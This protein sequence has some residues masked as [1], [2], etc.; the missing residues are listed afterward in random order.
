MVFTLDPACSNAAE[1]RQ[2][3]RRRVRKPIRFIEFIL[4]E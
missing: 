4:Q 1:A 2:I 3:Q